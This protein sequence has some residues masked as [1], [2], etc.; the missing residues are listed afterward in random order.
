M[1]TEFVLLSG[2]RV[3]KYY[4]IISFYEG[5]RYYDVMMGI[6]DN[7]KIMEKNTVGKLIEIRQYG[8]T[9]DPDIMLIFEDPKGNKLEYEPFFGCVEGFVEYEPD[10][11]AMSMER[12]Q[13]RTSI[14][15]VEIEGNDWALRP[16]NV[17]ATQGIDLSNW[18]N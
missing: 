4:K 6:I 12:I 13:K 18:A 5:V 15:K 14:L 17:V 1:T 3:G 2:V 16:E 7:K 10:T 9:Y 11:E 8:R